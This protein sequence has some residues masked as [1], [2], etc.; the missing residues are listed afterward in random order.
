MYSILSF[1]SCEPKDLPGDVQDL[2]YSPTDLGLYAAELALSSAGIDKSD[3]GLIIG[4]C[5]TPKELTPS[6]AQRL[7]SGLELQI[8]CFDLTAGTP[9][10]ACFFEYLRSTQVD[11]IA[12]NILWISSNCPLQWLHSNRLHSDKTEIAKYFSNG[13]ASAILSRVKE[14]RFQIKSSK[15]L[16]FFDLEMQFSLSATTNLFFDEDADFGVI[17]EC[18]KRL[19]LEAKKT[20]N[21]E[22]L[23]K[24]VV[25]P[26]ALK[27]TKN[28]ISDFKGDFLESLKGDSLGSSV[29]QLIYDNKETLI[30]GDK[31]LSF[32]VGPGPVGGY[33]LL[34]YL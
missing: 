22:E 20:V 8:P 3:L 2:S 6:E 21:F 13:A 9:A 17:D 29:P 16:S 12:E 25:N 18:V 19:I 5:S 33:F 31:I 11:K 4:D 28:F 34:E 32:M 26:L 15:Y 10:L 30:S 24:I 23:T 27:A 7:G 14:G 1:A